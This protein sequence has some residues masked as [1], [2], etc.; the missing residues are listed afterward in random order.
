M[1]PK[2]TET[3]PADETMETIAIYIALAKNAWRKVL[4]RLKDSWADRFYYEICLRIAEDRSTM[5]YS[6]EA[7]RPNIPVNVLMGLEILKAD[8][9]WSVFKSRRLLFPIA[10]A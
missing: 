3:I 6:H 5:L 1:H 9:G 8:H 10:L 4:Q 2:T 7:S